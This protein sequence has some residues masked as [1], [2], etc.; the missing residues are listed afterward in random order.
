MN[1]NN[2]ILFFGNNP[3]TISPSIAGGISFVVKTVTSTFSGGHFVQDVDL[4]LNTVPKSKTSGG[5]T[6]EQR[7]EQDNPTGEDTRKPQASS[8]EASSG[9]NSNTGDM[10]KSPEFSADSSPTSVNYDKANT[11]IPGQGVA[12]L[13]Q[14]VQATVPSRLGQV[15]ND[16][17]SPRGVTQ[18]DIDEAQRIQD[19]SGDPQAITA[20]Q[21]ASNRQL[22]SRL[23]QALGIPPGASPPPPFD[24]YAGG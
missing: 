2:K 17:N 4:V 24:P 18:K 10:R 13:I 9:G 22:N 19:D 20:Q 23:T 16:D 11:G 8:G 3:E 12:G 1:V 14:G 5:L 21:V 15:A 7:Q 6:E